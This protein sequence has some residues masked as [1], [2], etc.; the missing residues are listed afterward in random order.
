METKTKKLTAGNS[1]FLFETK[2]HFN[3]PIYAKALRIANEKGEQAAREY[4]EELRQR[5]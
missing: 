5:V 1:K 4:I 2:R 3:K